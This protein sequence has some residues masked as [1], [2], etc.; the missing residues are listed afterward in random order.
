MKDRLSMLAWSKTSNGSKQALFTAKVIVDKD[1]REDFARAY[2]YLRW[3]DDLVDMS[4]LSREEKV[5][6]V[7][8]QAE[9]IERFSRM[10]HV[11]GLTLE[12]EIL[13]GLLLRDSDA[14]QGL[15][16]FLRNMIAVIQF[17]AHRNGRLICQDELDWYTERVAQ[18]VTDGGEYFIRH[19]AP[20]PKGMDRLMA[21]KACHISH[22]LRDTLTDI[23]QGFINIPGEYLESS[24]IGPA[25]VGAHAY[26]AWVRGRVELARKYFSAGKGYYDRVPVMRVK[27]A[28]RW[29]CARFEDVLDCIERDGYV[30]RES[31]GGMRKVSLLARMFG[32]ALQVSARHVFGLA[33]ESSRA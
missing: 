26:R 8:R 18:S 14:N 31:Y 10:E 30:L 29:Y 11:P 19:S 16:S 3:A 15:R 12:E 9:L 4:V 28:V 20:D 27:A 7:D 5:S 17:D 24:G 13:A 33:P 21:V 25:E 23:A 22:L 32:V 2:A 1:L 6:F